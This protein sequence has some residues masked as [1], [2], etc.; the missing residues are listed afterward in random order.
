MSV[1]SRQNIIEDFNPFE[2]GDE[3]ERKTTGAEIKSPVENEHKQVIVSSAPDEKK[4][5]DDSSKTEEK[6]VINSTT[7]EITTN[8]FE[9]RVQ[10]GIFEE[11]KSADKCREEALSKVSLNVYIEFEAPF[12]RVR[13][14]DF[15]DKKE[16]EKYVKVM[17]E[18]G[19]KG[20]FWVIKNIR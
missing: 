15:K 4:N 5:I 18:N 3:F 13:V 16:A 19:F 1:P 17:Q 11:R 8:S 7:S 10:I 6:P 9:Y 20:A 14:G 2:Y 12:Y